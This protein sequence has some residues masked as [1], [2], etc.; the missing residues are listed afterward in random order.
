MGIGSKTAKSGFTS[1]ERFIDLVNNNQDFSN[2][3]KKFIGLDSNAL[4]SAQDIKGTEKGD[5]LLS[6]LDDSIKV[7]IK[8]STA[9]FSQLD[10][11]WL[12]NLKDAINMPQNIFEFLSEGL[13]SMRLN[14]PNKMLIQPQYSDKISEY[15]TRNLEPFLN[16]VFTRNDEKVKYFVVYN[17]DVATWYLYNMKE[18]IDFVSEATVSVTSKGVLRI[19]DYISVQRKGGDGN[20]TKVPKDHPLHPSNQ[21]QTKI[22]PLSIVN[23]YQGFT[24]KE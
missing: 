8:K 17:P 13:D 20:Y 10:R 5:V 24:I 12:T 21:L 3:I 18:I 22:K 19:G 15:F 6:Y 4:L 16:E 7:S 14:K 9:N 2:A 1:E 23:N 11:R